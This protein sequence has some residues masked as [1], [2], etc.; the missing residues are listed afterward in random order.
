[1]HGMACLYY[2]EWI[3][4]LVF[5][6]LPDW[7]VYFDNFTLSKVNKSMYKTYLVVLSNCHYVSIK[8]YFNDNSFHSNVFAKMISICNKYL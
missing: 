6:F 8:S 3:F 4:I 7:F 2:Y 5:V 1:M